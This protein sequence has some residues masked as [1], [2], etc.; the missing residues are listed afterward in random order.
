MSRQQENMVTA[1]FY[2]EKTKDVPSSVAKT[3]IS[4][5]FFSIPKQFKKMHTFVNKTD[6]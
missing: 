2:K 6:S 3:E 5:P 4:N 1:L